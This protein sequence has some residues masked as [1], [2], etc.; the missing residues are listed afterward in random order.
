MP[1]VGFQEINPVDE[2]TAA[3]LERIED[4]RFESE[5]RY[6]DLLREV[7]EGHK[8]DAAELGRLTSA[9]G[10]TDADFESDLQDR[11]ALLADE[12]ELARCDAEKIKLHKQIDGQA[13]IVTKAEEAKATAMNAAAEL[14]TKINAAHA[15][16]ALKEKTALKKSP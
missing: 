10:K 15:K 6:F 5:V 1:G 7:I 12:K 4:A 9:L 2:S 11:A 13:A 16:V 14:Q 8:P 3:A